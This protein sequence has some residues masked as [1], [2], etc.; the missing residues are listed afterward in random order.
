MCHLTDKKWVKLL[1]FTYWPTLMFSVYC[2]CHGLRQMHPILVRWEY[3][4]IVCHESYHVMLFKTLW[5]LPCS[6]ILNLSIF[7]C[8]CCFMPGG[9]FY[10]TDGTVWKI[11]ICRYLLESKN[12]LARMW[13]IWSRL[14]TTFSFLL[15]QFSLKYKFSTVIS[16]SYSK[17]GVSRKCF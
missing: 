8:W 16:P 9:T 1:S 17:M 11:D 12:P 14:S 13:H 15:N 2:V 4:E 3:Q 10:R 6:T 5:W 7:I